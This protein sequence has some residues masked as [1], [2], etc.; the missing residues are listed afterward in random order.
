MIDP[1][2]LSLLE[3]DR[4]VEV[5]YYGALK[6][7]QNFSA[8]NQLMLGLACCA[9]IRPLANFLRQ[10]N[11]QDA[12]SNGYAISRKTFIVGYGFLHLEK[13]LLL[14][15]DLLIPETLTKF[16]QKVR[17]DLIIYASEDF[18]FNNDFNG[19]FTL[20]EAAWGAVSII[21]RLGVPETEAGYRGFYLYDWGTQF[22]N[23]RLAM[24]RR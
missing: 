7:S 6:E 20:V 11:G 13:S 17:Q 9:A 10:R 15:P 5:L 18:Q 1:D 24:L 3:N 4:F 19:E 21:D 14:H 2:I 23:R 16:S 12:P 22:V 8:G